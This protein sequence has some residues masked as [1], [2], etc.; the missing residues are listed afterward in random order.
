M[1]NIVCK[2]GKVKASNE[3]ECLECRC[4]RFE[5]K[6]ERRQQI[7]KARAAKEARNWAIANDMLVA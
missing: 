2:C 4:A 5:S 7:A 3:N 1:E 6:R